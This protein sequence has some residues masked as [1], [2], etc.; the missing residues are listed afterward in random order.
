MD[1]IKGLCPLPCFQTHRSGGKGDQSP[2]PKE[3]WHHKKQTWWTE[4]WMFVVKSCV[5]EAVS[6][7]VAFVERPLGKIMS[8]P[9]SM[10]RNN[11]LAT[12]ATAH[13]HI[14]KWWTDARR[15]AKERGPL[16][17][18]LQK[19]KSKRNG[20]ATIKS[21]IYGFP[22]ST[23]SIASLAFCLMKRRLVEFDPN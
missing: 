5:A 4:E 23:Y 16:T 14:L 9:I 17:R 15:F 8:K 1:Q 13:L 20:R 21:K 19:K 12:T 2:I 7:K 6:S 11:H 22:I 3:F 18:V 10:K